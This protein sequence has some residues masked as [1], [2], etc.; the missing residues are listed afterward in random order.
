M[1]REDQDEPDHGG[2]A[3]FAQLENEYIF[4]VR[5]AYADHATQTVGMAQAPDLAHPWRL[6]IGKFAVPAGGPP[7]T[8]P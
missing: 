7:P 8:G 5:I 6:E 2:A 1:V 3:T 4:T